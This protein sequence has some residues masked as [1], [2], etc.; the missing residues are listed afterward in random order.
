LQQK[1]LGQAKPLAQDIV[2]WSNTT[3]RSG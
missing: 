3:S 1:Q 2:C